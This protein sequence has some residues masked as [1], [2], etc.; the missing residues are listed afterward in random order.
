MILVSNLPRV[1]FIVTCRS[2]SLG[3]GFAALSFV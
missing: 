3:Y 1:R 2:Q